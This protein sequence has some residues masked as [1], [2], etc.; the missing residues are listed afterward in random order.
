[1]Y[2]EYFGDILVR[3]AKEIIE[4]L[5][6]FRIHF[7]LQCNVDKVSF[8][9][10]LPEEIVASFQPLIDFV[11]AGYTF[12][13]IEIWDNQI[14][15]EAGFGKENF[16]SIV[17]VPFSAIVQIIIPTQDRIVRDI[18]VFINTV[19]LL[20]LDMKTDKINEETNQEDELLASSK[21]AILSNPNNKFLKH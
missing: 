8:E 19:S 2:K 3:H 17:S 10:S 5:L 18:C 7:Y 6:E 12:D 9:P 20:E 16:G 4:H 11:L 1:M 15:F 14:C 13:S 21:N